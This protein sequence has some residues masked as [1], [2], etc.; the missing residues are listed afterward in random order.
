M[1]AVHC[2]DSVLRVLIAIGHIHTLVAKEYFLEGLSKFKLCFPDGLILALL[3]SLASPIF[4]VFFTNHVWNVCWKM[5]HSSLTV[6]F[7]VIF[8]DKTVY[9][10]ETYF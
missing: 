9:A 2:Y 5:F 6:C 7:G 8:L 4:P 1:F 3:H 10:V